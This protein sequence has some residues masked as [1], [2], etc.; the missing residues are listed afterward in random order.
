MAKRDKEPVI[1]PQTGEGFDVAVVVDVISPSTLGPLYVSDVVS[2]NAAVAATTGLCK[3]A[4]L[5]NH[6]VFT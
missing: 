4:A 5:S 2:A 6:D 1:T 3:W